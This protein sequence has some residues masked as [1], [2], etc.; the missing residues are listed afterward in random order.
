MKLKRAKTQN[1]MYLSHIIEKRLIFRIHKVFKSV[2]KIKDY[3]IKKLP[4][5]TKKTPKQTNKQKPTN[6]PWAKS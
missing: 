6:Q 1:E 2:R 4:K 3:L 5:T